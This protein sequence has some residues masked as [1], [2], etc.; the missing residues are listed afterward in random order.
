M[1]NRP[2]IRLILSQEFPKFE[3]KQPQMDILN[4]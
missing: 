2:F 4:L 3:V 1:I